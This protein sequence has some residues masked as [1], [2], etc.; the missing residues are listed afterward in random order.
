M[1]ENANLFYSNEFKMVILVLFIS[2]I[3]FSIIYAKKLRNNRLL[4]EHN[5]YLK[6]EIKEFQNSLIEKNIQLKEIHHR[7]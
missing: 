1:I 5:I 3:I 6:N 4:K 7:V 2:I